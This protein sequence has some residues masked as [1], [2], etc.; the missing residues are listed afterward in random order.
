MSACDQRTYY[1]TVN[2]L[3]KLRTSD[4]DLVWECRSASDDVG[5]QDAFQHYPILKVGDTVAVM[6]AGASAHSMLLLV[7]EDA[8]GLIESVAEA[9]LVE[10]G[11]SRLTPGAQTDGTDFYLYGRHTTGTGDQAVIAK[12]DPNGV[13]LGAYAHAIGTVTTACTF[14]AFEDDRYNVRT[15]FGSS[16]RFRQYEQFTGTLMATSA[17][18]TVRS[19]GNR[20]TFLSDATHYYGVSGSNLIKISKDTL[21]TVLTVANPSGNR[22]LLG[23][24]RDGCLAACIFGSAQ[25]TLWN[26][27]TLVKLW[28]N[29]SLVGRVSGVDVRGSVVVAC[30]TTSFAA[31]NFFFTVVRMDISTGVELW[32]REFRTDRTVTVG[33]NTID[34][35]NPRVFV[36]ED[37]T[38]VFVVG[39]IAEEPFT[40]LGERYAIHCLDA[41]TG[42]TLWCFSVGPNDGLVDNVGPGMDVLEDGD[43]LYL[44][45]WKSRSPS[46]R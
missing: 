42:D 12:Y 9:G 41:D 20:L 23:V 33:I 35:A 18:M 14:D 46:Y 16:E 27:A 19:I 21:A 4:G 8:D 17:G 43:Y 11:L 38:K 5:S 36:S 13:F 10:Y 26:S 6:S 28:G 15:P 22:P 24:V 2:G 31:T 30:G 44:S 7:K 1:Q 3:F 40:A 45:A 37:E 25:I 39:P 32:E 34:E 29:N